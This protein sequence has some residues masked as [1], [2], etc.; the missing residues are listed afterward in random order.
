MILAERLRMLRQTRNI[1]QKELASYLNL[2]LAAVS[3]YE[4]NR[5]QP[6]LA[7]LCK[8]ADFY[9]VTTDYL[10]G[11]DTYPVLSPHPG[12][13]DFHITLRENIFLRTA[14]LSKDNLLAVE[15]LIRMLEHYEIHIDSLK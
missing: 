9:G 12:K 3:G 1:G 10:L 5:Y 7:T 6:D 14:A 4:R 11:R 8:L 2:S 13:K 15:W